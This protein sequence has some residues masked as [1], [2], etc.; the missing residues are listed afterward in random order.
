MSQ[1]NSNNHQLNRIPFNELEVLETYDLKD[2]NLKSNKEVIDHALAQYPRIMAIRFDLHFP[3]CYSDIDYDCPHAGVVITTFINSLK[4]KIQSNINRRRKNNKRAADCRLNYIWVKEGDDDTAEHYHVVI[5]LN[6][7]TFNSLG[8]YGVLGDNLYTK[9]IEAWANALKI[10]IYDTLN[11]THFPKKNI[12][13]LKKN[14]VNFEEV[15]RSLYKR[16]SYFAK[17][18]TKCCGDNQRNYGSSDKKKRYACH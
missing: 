14:A 1:N 3:R 8:V 12:Y 17:V 13:Y 15:Y 5:F 7:D 10:E 4:A 11:L 2:D 9:I 18:D 6:N 16:I